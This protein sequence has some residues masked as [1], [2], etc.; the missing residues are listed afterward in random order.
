MRRIFVVTLLL[1]LMSLLGLALPGVAHGGEA[2]LQ[3][4]L[5]GTNTPPPIAFATNTPAGPSPT[6]TKTPLPTATETATFTPSF[7]PTNT[8]TPTDT[9]APT[10]TPNGPFVYPEG[11]N[12]LTGL[13]YP[14]AEAM[15][16]R[17]L[18]VKISNYPPVVRPQSGVNQADL[19]FEYETEGGVTRFAAIFRSNAPTHVGSVR[20]A[21]LIDL[22]LV[23]M[24][25]AL[26][27]YSGTSAPIQQLIL[28]NPDNPDFTF[29]AFSPLKGDNCEDSGF[30]RF[31]QDGLAFEH[32]L[33]L[34][35]TK[36]WAEATKRNVNTGYRA[37]GFAFSPI[38]D[39]GGLPAND[40]FIDWYGQTDARWQYDEASGHWLRYTDGVAHYDADDGQQLWADNLVIIEVPHNDHPDI[41][42]PGASYTSIQ[43]Q[44]WDQGRAYLLRDGMVYQ[45]YWRRRSK[46]PGDAL[47][48]IYGNNTP[49]MMKP[50]RTWVSVVRG[51]GDV[52]ISDQKADMVAT[53][54]A[55]A[56]I[57]SPTPNPNALDTSDSGG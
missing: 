6:A 32:T 25:Q 44:L 1:G 41:F 8:N 17:N 4:T 48:I 7:T 5:P 45:G 15:A 19:V 52:T 26:L 18:I 2:A 49:I 51:F 57:A 28:H 27:A 16:R 50:G 47:Q 53:A 55:L 9:P 11:V 34:D 3:V 54:T 22:E 30:C 10:A 21:R 46:D 43:I 36:L 35:T 13:P 40:A 20:S 42:P 12:P 39:A 29:F 56:S 24:Y 14:N 23:P 33:F 37:R 38:P 31:P